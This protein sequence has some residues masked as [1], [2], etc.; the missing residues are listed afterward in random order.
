[1]YIFAGLALGFFIPFIARRLGKVLPVTT[2]VLLYKIPHLPR[3]P[4][5]HNPLQHKNFRKKWGLLLLNAGI[6][7]II[8]ASLFILAHYTLPSPLFIYATI[9]IWI[10]LCSACVDV[11]FFL[12]PDC[13]TIP[14]LL[15]GFYFAITT[16]IITPQQSI[17]GAFFAYIITIIAVLLSYK[18]RYNLFGGGDSKMIIAL[19]SWL[20]VEGINYTFLASFF[21]FLI[22]SFWTK[23]KTGAYGPALSL[24]ALLCFFTL[25]AK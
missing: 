17:Y 21:I 20:G 2:G 3:F 14:L 8:T 22:Y 15:I 23:N 25:Y 10:M 12:L 1:M 24:A 5:A 11:R 6:M 9:F 18:M 16:H 19:G 7:A 13:L 4:H